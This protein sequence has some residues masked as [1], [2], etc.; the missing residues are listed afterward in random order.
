MSWRIESLASVNKERGNMPYRAASQASVISSRAR[1]RL[2]DPSFVDSWQ[3]GHFFDTS[4]KARMHCS[5]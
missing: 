4:R 5:Y 2:T 1:L 3:L